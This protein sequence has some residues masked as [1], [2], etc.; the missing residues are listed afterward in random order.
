MLSGASGGT[1]QWYLDGSPIS[2]ASSSSYYATAS[3]DYNM[4]KTN[5]NGCSDSASLA[6]SVVTITVDAGA[7][8]IGTSLTADAN[9]LTYQWLDCDNG[10]TA[11]AGETNQS[12]SPTAV[13]GNYAV[14]VTNNGCA[15]T[16]AC[17]NVDFTGVT[18]LNV[19]GLSI[20]PNPSTNY[21][22][23]ESVNSSLESIE[24]LDN[25]GRI[26]YS[27]YQITDTKTQ[28]DDTKLSRGLYLIN[29]YGE[30]G[31]ITKEIIIH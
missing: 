14:E 3:G 15:D 18:D 9:G 5:S 29:L 2:G 21:F 4:I 22:F 16:S 23:V 30:F 19:L 25:S 10:Y 28:V 11:I 7:T 17:F 26:V 24:I 20:Y 8:Q 6:T 1:L 31:R 27:N 13:V 12:F